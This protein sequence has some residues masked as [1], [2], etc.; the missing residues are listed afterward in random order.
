MIN[1]RLIHPALGECCIEM[2]RGRFHVTAVINKW[3]STYGKKF[4]ECTVVEEKQK[5]VIMKK[6]QRNETPVFD[7][8]TN[9][10]YPS[11]RTAAMETGHSQQ[12]IR[13]HVDRLLSDCM[14]YRFKYAN[15]NK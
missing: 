15:S 13:N 6:G 1:I 8:V 3:K 5:K 4:Y 10:T 2:C 7:K 14:N 12:H 9:E 11:V